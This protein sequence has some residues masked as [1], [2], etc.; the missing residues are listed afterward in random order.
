[1]KNIFINTLV[2]LICTF[3]V[4][5]SNAQNFKSHQSN[6]ERVTRHSNQKDNVKSLD[7][8]KHKKLDNRVSQNKSFQFKRTERN[9]DFSKLKMVRPNKANSSLTKTVAVRKKEKN[10]ASTIKNIKKIENE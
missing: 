10:N 4:N 7:F 5:T 3:Y 9:K 8:I 6:K 1:M 2:I